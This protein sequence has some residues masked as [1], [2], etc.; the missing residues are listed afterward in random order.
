[1]LR[2]GEKILAKITVVGVDEISYLKFG[3]DSP[4]Y[5]IRKSEVAKISYQNGNKDAFNSTVVVTGAVPIILNTQIPQKTYMDGV[6]DAH[7]YYT[8][9]SSGGIVTGLT[10]FVFSPFGGVV[11]ALVCSSIRPPVRNLGIRDGS[12]FHDNDYMRGYSDEARK[13]KRRKIWAYF[14][15]GSAAWFVLLLYLNTRH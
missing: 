15:Y 9:Q 1:M 4:T 13:I 14:G 10:T 6:K 12:L 3:F 11:P 7:L 5:T 2:T 8:A